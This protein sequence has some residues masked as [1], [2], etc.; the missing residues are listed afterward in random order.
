ML[1]LYVYY[2]LAQEQIPLA[3]SGVAHLFTA[4]RPFCRSVRLMQ[5]QWSADKPDKL[6]TWM[7]I[8][9]D[10]PDLDRLQQCLQQALPDSGLLSAIQ[11]QRHCECFFALG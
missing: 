10:V 7:E 4:A 3:Q 1:Q 2:Q 11:G 5:R 6:L 9:V 8:Y